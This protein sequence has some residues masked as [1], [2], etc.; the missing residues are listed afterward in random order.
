MKQF[1]IVVPVLLGA[2]PAFA[3]D[4]IMG[5]APDPMPME[6]PVMSW[7]GGYVGLQAGA[8]FGDTGVWAMDT[9]GDGVFGDP[10]APF[11]DNFAGSFEEGFV[12]GAHAGYDWQRGNFVF[13]GIVDIAATDIGDRQ[14]G[15]SSTPAFYDIERNLDYLATARLRAGVVVAE[16]FLPYV[17]GGLAYGDVEERFVTN[18]PAAF[19][20]SGGDDGRFG[21][22][23]GGGVEARVTQQVSLGFEYLYT[24]LGDSDFNVNLNSGPFAAVPAGSTDARGSDRDFDFHTIQMKLSYRF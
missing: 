2:T 22:T 12:G 1:A 15:F 18:T 17:T 5:V 13:G 11:G 8:G 3:A 6:A 14:S 7:T 9:D 23:V 4:A 21:Y 16:R 20:T 10:F 19:T 24:N